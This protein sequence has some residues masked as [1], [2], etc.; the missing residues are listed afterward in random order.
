VEQEQGM[1]AVGGSRA[2]REGAVQ[3]LQIFFVLLIV[4]V[5]GR[6]F[7]GYYHILQVDQAPVARP[8][9]PP[10]TKAPTGP[11]APAA[12]SAESAEA[13]PAW[14]CPVLE[15]AKGHPLSVY[16]LPMF[17]LIV[18]VAVRLILALRSFD[19]VYA[20]SAAWAE[21]SFTGL[22]L[23]I[24]FLLGQVGLLAFMAVALESEETT[25]PMAIFFVGLLVVS[26][27]W[28]LW[29]RL[30]A[31][32]EDRQALSYALPAGVNDL[33]FAAAIFGALYLYWAVQPE[34][35]GTLHS[36]PGVLAAFLGI[37]G[38]YLNYLIAVQAPDDPALTENHVLRSWLGI[39]IGIV[40]CA[41]V[42]ACTVFSQKIGL[43]LPL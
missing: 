21:R 6:A 32:A 7:V 39:G 23:H 42:V 43:Y 18:L 13:K 30:T 2:A 41:I 26:G 36:S 9:A 17:I 16:R 20:E 40:V 34:H 15:F 12:K 22:L 37:I 38:T 3:A 10:V 29:T 5:M 33:A 28:Y 31:G 4:L 27:V 11:A 8:S 24:G 14:T 25:D 19:R 1:E 35:K